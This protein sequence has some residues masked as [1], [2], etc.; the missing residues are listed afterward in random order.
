MDMFESSCMSLFSS[1]TESTATK[2][3]LFWMLTLLP[4]AITI[5]LEKIMDLVVG[6]KML[7]LPSFHT[8]SFE[9][10]KFLL[11]ILFSLFEIHPWALE[12]Y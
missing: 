7:R 12:S 8:V 4:L 3:V 1:S 11:L 9:I 2:V 6:F 5:L 10:L